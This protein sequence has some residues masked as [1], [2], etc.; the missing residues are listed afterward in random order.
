MNSFLKKT[1]IFVFVMAAVAG[2]GW[3]GRKVYK[4]ATERRLLAEAHQYLEKKDLR[5][6]N[7]CLQ[8]VLQINPFNPE[9]NGLTADTL[10]AAGIPAALNWR[11]RVV[12]LQ[13]NN[14]E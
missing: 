2:A 7:L 10:E 4:K 1:L 13:T 9:A 6:A 3:F 5:N 8:R 12:Q 14:M 11:I